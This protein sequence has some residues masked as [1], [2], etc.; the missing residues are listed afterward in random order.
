V[1]AFRREIRGQVVREVGRRAKFLQIRLDRHSLL[2]HLRMS[3]DVVLRDRRAA[4][5]K[6]DRLIFSLSGGRRLVFNDARKFGRVWLDAN[7]PSV[8]QN[9]GPEPLGGAF[10]ADWFYGGLQTHRRQLKPL[11]L[12]QSFLAGLGNIYT[13]ESLHKAKLHPL[14][15]S[16]AVKRR[17]AEALHRAIRGVLRAAIRRN[18]TSIDWVYRGGSY[19]NHFRV[20]DREGK[21]CRVCGTTIQRIVVGQ[22]GTHLCPRCQKLR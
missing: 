19:Q 17:E 5:Q 3:G 10:S 16:N 15:L 1:R 12:D 4:V 14:I 22:R 6:H 11:L 20:Y 21:P 13:D 18:G 9:L 7:P 2:I 8:L